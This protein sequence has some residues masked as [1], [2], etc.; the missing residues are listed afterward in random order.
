MKGL[1]EVFNIP[2]RIFI[3]V[4]CACCVHEDINR[5]EN[6]HSQH[7]HICTKPCGLVLHGLDCPS[8]ELEVLIPGFV[9]GSEETTD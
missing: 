8:Q 6:F 5:L 9:L 4:M 2:S 7:H 3:V 1:T